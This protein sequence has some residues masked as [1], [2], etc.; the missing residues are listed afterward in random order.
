MTTDARRPVQLVLPLVALPRP[1]WAE[2]EPYR[3]ERRDGRPR[4]C[5]MQIMVDG[6]VW[7]Y[8]GGLL[9]GEPQYEPE[10]CDADR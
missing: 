7:R 8:V 6:R 5:P 3:S 10:V 4:S 2:T 9:T 1:G